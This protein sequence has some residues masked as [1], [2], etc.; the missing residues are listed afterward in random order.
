MLRYPELI[1][2]AE[3]FDTILMRAAKGRMI[4]KV[5][6][7]GVWLGGVLPCGQFPSGLA[8]ALKIEDGDDLYSRSVVAIDVLRQLGVVA[9][10]DLAQLSP[11]PIKNRR[12]DKVGEI[13]SVV[14]I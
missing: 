7:E 3:R 14:Q 4:S 6:A 1:G 12:G 13:V 9:P 11:M 8:I 10:D 5:G 2:G